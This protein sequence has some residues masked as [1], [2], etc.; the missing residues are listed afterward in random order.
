M[1]S[2]FAGL[3]GSLR[4]AFGMCGLFR[5][6]NM[7]QLASKARRRPRNLQSLISATFTSP[8]FLSFINQ[9]NTYTVYVHAYEPPL[10]IHQ[11]HVPSH[12]SRRRSSHL[13]HATEAIRSAPPG[14]EVPAP[15]SSNPRWEDLIKTIQHSLD[16]KKQ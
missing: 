13:P 2:L 14:R 9:Q 15:S 16:K 6:L 7:P 12:Q 11:T 4:P 5:S 1:V 3:W 10:T 8:F